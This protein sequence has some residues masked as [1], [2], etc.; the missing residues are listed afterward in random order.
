MSNKTDN[1]TLAQIVEDCAMLSIDERLIPAQQAMF[2]QAAERLRA[3]LTVLLVKTFNEGTPAL[4]EANAKITTVNA[5]LKIFAQQLA[6]AANM[7]E[8]VSKLVS[9]LDGLAKIPLAVI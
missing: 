8:H 3:Q 5:Q 7:L 6:N 4:I 1:L 9:V 2:A